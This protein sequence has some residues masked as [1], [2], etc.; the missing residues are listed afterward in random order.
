[1]QLSG[2]VFFVCV[3]VQR[4]T[5]ERQYLLIC[6]LCSEFKTSPGDN[7]ALNETGDEI[8]TTGT[9]AIF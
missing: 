9:N 7:V 8:S 2:F 4:A 6:A 1:M 5:R 3:Y